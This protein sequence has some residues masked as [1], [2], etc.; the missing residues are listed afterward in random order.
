MKFAQINYNE[1]VFTAEV[2]GDGT[3]LS[4]PVR[5]LIEFV[6][7]HHTSSARYILRQP[8]ILNYEPSVF[9]KALIKV[10]AKRFRI[11]LDQLPANKVIRCEPL[12]HEP[13]EGF[14]SLAFNSQAEVIS[15]VQGEAE[16]T[17]VLVAYV[18]RLHQI[19]QIAKNSNA[20]VKTRHAEMN[21]LEKLM[22][23]RPQ[24]GDYIVV[25]LQSCRMCAAALAEW[26]GQENITVYFLKPEPAL[27]NV[28]T[29]L[30]GKEK[31]AFTDLKS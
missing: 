29:A 20:V 14:D 2:R 9:E 16:K 26:T 11:E 17:G 15:W 19:I 30:F 4:S 22:N 5:T 1:K 3:L 6:Y 28:K 25:S 8:I 24:A 12:P 27:T 10:A 21:L 23:I 13:E 7:A 18:S 31:N